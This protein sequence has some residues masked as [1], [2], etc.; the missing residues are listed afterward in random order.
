MEPTQKSGAASIA[1]IED[2]GLKIPSKLHEHSA[3]GTVQLF[4]DDAVVLIPTPSPDP[5]GVST[6]G[7]SP[8]RV[9]R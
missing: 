7:S 8:V 4:Q 9:N 1:A 5:K 2:I 6:H 3:S